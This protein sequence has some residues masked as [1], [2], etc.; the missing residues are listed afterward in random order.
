[1]VFHRYNQLETAEEAQ[2][3]TG[4]KLVSCQFPKCSLR[5]WHVKLICGHAPAAT[6]DCACNIRVI[7]SNSGAA[8]GAWGCLPGAYQLSPAVRICGHRYFSIAWLTDS[9]DSL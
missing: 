1:M 9:E 7:D 6:H 4:W 8:A 3:E 2:E 5:A